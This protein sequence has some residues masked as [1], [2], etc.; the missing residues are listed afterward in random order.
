ML[1]GSSLIGVIIHSVHTYKING[2]GKIN[3]KINIKGNVIMLIKLLRNYFVF[4]FQGVLIN[5]KTYV[6]IWLFKE[7]MLWLLSLTKC[8]I[9]SNYNQIPLE[10][11]QLHLCKNSLFTFCEYKCIYVIPANLFISCTINST[12]FHI[13]RART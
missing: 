6:S 9:F 10:N 4:I 13:W 7:T 8:A 2:N 1:I 3:I 5:H 12:H 11:E